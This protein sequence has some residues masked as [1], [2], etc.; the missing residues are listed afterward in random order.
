MRRSDPQGYA[1]IESAKLN[2]AIAEFHART[3]SDDVFLACLYARGFRGTRLA[4]EFRYQD[5][6]RYEAEQREVS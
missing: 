5:Q 1:E 2:T 6:V 3:I 4:G